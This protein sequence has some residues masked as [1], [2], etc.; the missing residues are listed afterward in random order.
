MSF[1]VKPSQACMFSC[2]AFMT[3][4]FFQTS[5]AVLWSQPA[6]GT[7]LSGSFTTQTGD[8]SY[9]RLVRLAHG[10][11]NGTIVASESLVGS[12]VTTNICI[13]LKMSVIGPNLAP[14]WTNRHT[15]WTPELFSP[16]ANGI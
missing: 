6:S 5:P 3:E 15:I 12:G 7:V 16:T 14:F 8:A 1:R 11:H 13:V 2:M 4:A 9:F 10:L